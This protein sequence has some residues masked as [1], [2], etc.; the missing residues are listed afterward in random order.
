MKW[1]FITKAFE[2]SNPHNFTVYG[3]YIIYA[4]LKW[5]C[6]VYFSCMIALLVKQCCFFFIENYGATYYGLVVYD[7]ITRHQL[8]WYNHFDYPKKERVEW[9]EISASFLSE[10]C[11]SNAHVADDIGRWPAELR[12]RSDIH[13]VISIPGAELHG[14]ETGHPSAS[15]GQHR[16]YRTLFTL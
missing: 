13:Q 12:S 3:W 6:T 11:I 14:S 8:K 5:K 9:R 1:S 7:I 10:D 15:I 2:Q 4:F 16:W